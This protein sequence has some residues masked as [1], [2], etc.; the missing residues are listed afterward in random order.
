MR[1]IEVAAMC[2]DSDDGLGELR[3]GFLGGVPK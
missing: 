2:Q 3:F 1:L